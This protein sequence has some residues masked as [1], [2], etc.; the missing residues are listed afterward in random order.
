[1][2]IAVTA[3]AGGGIFFVH[4]FGKTSGYQPH[5]WVYA[6]GIILAW[7]PDIDILAQKAK[8]QA[9]DSKHRSM[10]THQ[11]MLFMAITLGATVLLVGTSA[12]NHAEFWLPL[13]TLCLLFHYLHDSLGQANRWG[14]EWLAPFSGRL[15]QI[16]MIKDGKR[17]LVCSWTPEE[18]GKIPLEEWLA[19]YYLR[20]TSESIGGIL[21]FCLAVVYATLG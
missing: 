17:R 15:Y 21:T 2:A 16:G 8:S 11:P 18:A 1:M 9:I 7:L 20:P 6:L 10:I 13:V 5:W 4:L 3:D 14:I 12:P 19:T